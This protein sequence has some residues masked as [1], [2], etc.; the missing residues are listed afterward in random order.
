MCR[1]YTCQYQGPLNFAD[2]SIFFAKIQHFST[3]IAPLLKAIVSELRQRFFS[4]VFSSCKL[5][6]Y[7]EWKYKFYRLCARIQLP[8]SNDVTICWNDAIVKYFDVLFLLSS[9][10][11]GPSF[12]SISSMF[13]SHD[14]FLLQGIQMPPSEFWPTFGDWDELGIPNLA[15]MTLIKSYWML[16]NAMNFVV[17]ECFWLIKGKPTGG[18]INPDP[19]RLGLS[20]ENNPFH[21]IMEMTTVFY[22]RWRHFDK[23]WRDCHFFYIWWLV[24]L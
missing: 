13:W 22:Q 2:V 10:V 16:E 19:P 7:Y 12:M 15:Q 24:F 1:K 5:K 20:M 6:G 21:L 14:N 18:E 9:L 4:S 11:T 23:F 3:K 8:A 17:S